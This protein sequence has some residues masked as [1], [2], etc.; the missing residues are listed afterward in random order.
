MKPWIPSLITTADSR[1]LLNTGPMQQIE[2][3]H[4]YRNINAKSFLRWFVSISFTLSAFYRVITPIASDHYPTP[5]I[6]GST[7]E[8]LLAVYVTSLSPI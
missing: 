2:L 3:L 4:A 1:M 6:V 7:D 8:A 5:E